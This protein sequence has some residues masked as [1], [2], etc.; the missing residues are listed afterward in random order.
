MQLQSVHL[1]MFAQTQ[2]EEDVHANKKG[3]LLL[4]GPIKIF[5]HKKIL[6]VDVP[7]RI[8]PPP[9]AY[10]IYGNQGGGG[11]KGGKNLSANTFRADALTP[12][13]GGQDFSAP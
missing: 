2:A 3:I 10:I 12:R 1:V 11:M 6:S 5:I 4:P 8:M 9:G 7:F 13:G